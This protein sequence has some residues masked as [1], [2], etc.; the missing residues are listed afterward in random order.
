ML[1]SAN[2]NLTLFG[3]SL[4]FHIWELDDLTAVNGCDLLS[5]GTDRKNYT[6]ALPRLKQ[7]R[8]RRA[9]LPHKILRRTL[10]TNVQENMAKK[11]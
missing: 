4:L 8:A 3:V 6:A 5:V 10:T 11:H 2:G 7:L 1:S 9:F